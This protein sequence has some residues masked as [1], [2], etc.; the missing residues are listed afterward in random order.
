MKNNE[1]VKTGT[2]A[3]ILAL[4]TSFFLPVIAMQNEDEDWELAQAIA[5]SLEGISHNPTTQNTTPR[6]PEEQDQRLPKNPFADL[7]TNLTPLMRAI[8]NENFPLAMASIDPKTINSQEDFGCTAL[9]FAAESEETDLVVALLQAGADETLCDF[10]GR[11]AVDAARDAQIENGVANQEIIEVLSSWQTTREA[12]GKRKRSHAESA[13]L[14]TTNGAYAEGSDSPFIILLKTMFN[15]RDL[16][17]DVVSEAQFQSAGTLLYAASLARAELLHDL[18]RE[19][20]RIHDEKRAQE[21]RLAKEQRKAQRSLRR[22]QKRARSNTNISNGTD[23][24]LDFDENTAEII[25]SGMDSLNNMWADD[26]QP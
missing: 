6:V 13:P 19:F 17:A 12:G 22:A 8:L 1:F 25:S 26:D 20:A 18:E 10:D 9:H 3:V 21:K 2:I 16:Y 4:S 23:L 15:T 11:S 24:Q 5:L 7:R 14:P